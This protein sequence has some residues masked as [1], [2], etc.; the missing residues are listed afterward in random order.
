MPSPVRS[1]R[2]TATR[3]E[4]SVQRVLPRFL[5]HMRRFVAQS[6]HGLRHPRRVNAGEHGERPGPDSLHDRRRVDADAEVTL[7][8]PF[9][10]RLG[11]PVR[12]ELG[13]RGRSAPDGVHVRRGAADVEHEQVAKTG[14]AVDTVREQARGLQHG[15]RRWHRDAPDEGFHAV[16]PLG[17]HDA[18]HERLAHRRLRRLDID[19]TELRHDIVHH[20]NWNA[21]ALE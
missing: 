4:R 14:L 13:L 7:D 1:Y 9:G 6:L 21:R 15:H 20:A 3:C 10:V 12:D 5:G 2:P 19:A 11:Q 18:V 8:G 17:G 16:E